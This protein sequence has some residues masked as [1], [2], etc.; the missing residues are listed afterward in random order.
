LEL[1][2]RERPLP[3]LKVLYRNT[4][5]IREVGGR[6]AEVLRV[7]EPTA[8]P[9]GRVG[10]EILREA[11]RAKDVDGAERTF[12]ALAKGPPAGA[13]EQLLLR[14]RGRTAR[15]ERPGKPAG[16]VHG[17]SIGVHASDSANAWR[18][19]ARVGGPRNAFACLILGA[20]QV[21]FDRVARGGDFLHWTPQP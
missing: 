9:A 11:V 4:N 17:D 13:V 14:D 20:Y 3:V 21:A 19:L 10:G 1:P 15:D 12:A 2:E 8:P 5:R 16:S 7:V 6:R 18:N